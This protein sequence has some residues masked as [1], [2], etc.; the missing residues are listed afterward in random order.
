MIRTRF[1]PSPTGPLHLGH[2]YSAITAHD[3]AR[4]HKGQFL[5]RIEDIDQSRA[6]TTWENQIYDDLAWL[7]LTW[8]GQ[9]MRQS[10]RTT[11]YSTAL[12]Q[13]W[14][15]G[16]IYCCTCSRRDIVQASSAPQEGLSAQHTGPDGLV[17]PGS[18]RSSTKDR[19]W[20]NDAALR[21]NISEALKGHNSVTFKNIE[22]DI[23]RPVFYIK[24]NLQMTDFI[25]DF[26][27]SRRVNEA[28]YHLAVV[29]DDTAQAITHV[30]RGE[31]LKSATPIHILLQRLLGH[32]TPTYMHHPLIRDDAG[33]RLAKRDDAKAIGKFR[34]E[35]ASPANIRAMIGL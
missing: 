14:D 21:I 20:I 10:Q 26:V 23:N 6:R 7:G 24:D 29:V 31:D 34:A 11:A 30:V 35:G 8:D 5:L 16:L 1:A 2:A 15:A 32:P 27:V 9:V 19:V 4:T 17:Y 3:F 22:S 33:K 13:L 18:C 12:N 25:G 28:A